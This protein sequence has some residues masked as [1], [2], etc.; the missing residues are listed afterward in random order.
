MAF[1]YNVSGPFESGT[2]QSELTRLEGIDSGIEAIFPTQSGGRTLWYVISRRGVGAND[3]IGYAFES[4]ESV[5]TANGETYIFTLKNPS[6]SGKTLALSILAGTSEGVK[7]VKV[8]FYKN[9][10]LSG[11]PSFNAV[12]GGVGETDIAATAHTGGTKKGF[13]GIV[14]EGSVSEEV[15]KLQLVLDEG[16]SITL[17][18]ETSQEA[19]VT[20]ALMWEERTS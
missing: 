18:A 11:S 3:A 5:A 12:N 10:N 1:D 17:T 9:A 16:D 14:K 4:T 15:S 2:V 19:S 8:R 13:F 20:L 7:P 6:G